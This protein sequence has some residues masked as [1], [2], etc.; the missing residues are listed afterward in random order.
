MTLY[1]GF[2]SLLQRSVNHPRCISLLPRM[3]PLRRGTRGRPANN[4]RVR[5]IYTAATP[6][7]EPL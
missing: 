4:T 7:S 5:T 3:V 2:V 1:V 6:M